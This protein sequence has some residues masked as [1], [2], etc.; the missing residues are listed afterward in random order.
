MFFVYFILFSICCK[1]YTEYSKSVSIKRPPQNKL[2]L[3]YDGYDYL[4]AVIVRC[5][6]IFYRYL[7]HLIRKCN[8]K[9]FRNCSQPV[10]S[11][12]VEPFLLILLPFVKASLA[13]YELIPLSSLEFF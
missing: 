12:L 9:A 2:A 1:L 3:F 11:A 8:A 10:S 7:F 13:C 5:R 4:L 6:S